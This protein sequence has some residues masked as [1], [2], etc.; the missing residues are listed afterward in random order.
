[1]FVGF[2]K[3][4]REEPDRMIERKMEDF[5]YIYPKG[6][7]VLISKDTGFTPVI[8][9]HDKKGRQIKL[10][11]DDYKEGKIISITKDQHS[12]LYKLKT[13][14]TEEKDAYPL[15]YFVESLKKNTPQNKSHEMLASPSREKLK[16]KPVPSL[17][18]DSQSELELLTRKVLMESSVMKTISAPKSSTPLSFFWDYR[19]ATGPNQ[20]TTGGMIK[21]IRK[22]T[23]NFNEVDFLTFVEVTKET[24]KSQNIN[25]IYDLLDAYVMVGFVRFKDE[26]VR[27]IERKMEDFFS[28]H[29][30]GWAVLISADTGFTSA[31][32]RH[33]DV[34]GRKIALIY[35]NY[36]ENGN[37]ISVTK[38]DLVDINKM[39][40]SSDSPHLLSD[41]AH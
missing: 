24:L 29:T 3:P 19:Y 9:N 10:I 39:F 35:N 7:A 38:Q 20:K 37:I 13:S 36:G 11:Y 5:F 30:D 33:Q 8:I 18:K 28:I 4:K 15:S 12:N 2:S 14:V 40:N 27:M 16:E 31:I 21:A 6:C 34:K 22:F 25:K 17:Q 23:I 26:A 32:T 41:I 1:V